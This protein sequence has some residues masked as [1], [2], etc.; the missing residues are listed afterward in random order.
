MRIAISP[1]FAT[2]TLSTLLSDT[3]AVFSA[4]VSPAD[5]LTVARALSVPVVVVLYAWPFSGHAYWATAIFCVA[6]TTDFFDGRLA[7]RHGRSSALGSLLDPIADKV[8]VLGTLVM[9]VGLR[10]VPAW[11]VA[12]IVVREVL[13]TGLR[14]AAIERGVV[15]AAR[16]LGKLKT[17][18]QAVAAALGGFAAA[19][20]WS[21][22]GGWWALLVAGVLTWG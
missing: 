19:D 13:I 11:M 12:A 8:L 10:V 15:L 22:R 21:G 6:M 16:D 5:Q 7:R 2:R 4:F 17:W 18:A 9:L 14:Q 3:G 1:R 20:A